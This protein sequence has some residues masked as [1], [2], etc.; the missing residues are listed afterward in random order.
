MRTKTKKRR[1]AWLLSLL[2]ALF[3]LGIIG[4]YIISQNQNESP[5]AT[6]TKDSGT[7]KKNEKASTPTQKSNDP[8]EEKVDHLLKKMTL[9][10]KVGQL[11]I[12][13]F[14][15]KQ[16]DSLITAMIRDYHVGG[17][18]LYDRNMD[19]PNQVTHLTSDLQRL[20]LENTHQIPLI[21]SIDQEGG[22]I[23][24]MRDHVSPIPSQQDLARNKNQETVYNTAVQTGS[25]LKAMGINVNYAPVLDLS[26]LDSRSFGEDPQKAKELGEKVIAGFTK[27]G[28]TATLK[29]FPGNGRSNID[30]HKDTSAVQA[31]QLDL[32]NNDIYP[33]KKII[34]EVNHQNFF[35]MV[36]H[37]KYPAYDKENPASL[38]PIIIQQ[39]LRNK[40]GYKG[41]VVTDDLEMGAVSK[42][43]SY[44]EL[45]YSAVKAGADLLL[46]CH[47]FDSQKEVINGMIEAVKTNKLSEERINESVKRI[48]TY[49]F[50]ST[51]MDA[52]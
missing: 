29:H 5:K 33:F 15:T 25:E 22:Q 18:I 1:K 50:S 23:V 37:I 35:V 24:R 40:L 13:G 48:L 44:K 27:S 17:V 12:V 41:I 49:K 38:S 9:E 39:L 30:P 43:Y 45:G 31:N 32:E 34:E 19:S 8:I 2:C 26:N 46:V 36:T 3:T 7:V 51:M 16:P 11:V 4:G 42:Y 14:Q 21:V 10:E 6:E 47:T 20:A 52:Q 28:I